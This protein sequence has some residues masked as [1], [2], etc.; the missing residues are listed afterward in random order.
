M[1]AQ[2]P[3]FSALITALL[4]STSAHGLSLGG[5]N[6]PDRICNVADANTAAERCKAGDLLVFQPPTFGNEQYPV[7]ISGAFCDFSMQVVQ[8]VGGVAC[9]FSTARK[10]DWKAFGI[11][12]N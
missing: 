7:L 12:G 11:G 2:K 3:A 9:V 1:N 6:D 4:L 10:R 5:G 8:T